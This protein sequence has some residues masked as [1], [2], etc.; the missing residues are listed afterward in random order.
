M[1]LDNVIGV[2]DTVMSGGDVDESF[3]DDSHIVGYVATYFVEQERKSGLFELIRW[4]DMMRDFLDLPFETRNALDRLNQIH[5]INDILDDESSDN[6]PNPQIIRRITEEHSDSAGEFYERLYL[7]KGITEIVEQ[8]IEHEPNSRRGYV[9]IT[10]WFQ[11]YDIKNGTNLDN[12]KREGIRKSGQGE[13]FYD[14]FRRKKRKNE[15][16][17]DLPFEEWLESQIS[18]DLSER[19]KQTPY[20]QQENV[21]I[22]DVVEAYIK[23]QPTSRKGDVPITNWFVRYGIN[24]ETNLNN[25]ESIRKLKQG[26]KFYQ[27]FLEKRKNEIPEDLPFEEW[28]ESQIS[29]ELS[30]RLKQTPYYQNNVSIEDVVE[31]Y[32]KHK[33]TSRKGDVSIKHWFQVYDVKTG[34]SLDNSKRDGTKKAGQ[35]NKFYWEWYEK[36][37]KNETPEDLPFENWLESQISSELSER[38]KQTPYYQ[39]NVSIEDVVEA[40]IQYQPTSRIGYV[41]ITSW[42]N[43][44]DI[45]TG[46]NLD[47]RKKG[48]ARKSRQGSKFYGRWRKNEKDK[49][50]FEEW[51][52]SQVS[53]EV[54]ERYLKCVVKSTL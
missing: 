24:T 4:P 9:P 14:I 15:I 1:T 45:K 7:R 8:F 18:S 52:L 26:E 16:P 22:E 44:Y 38:L 39:N 20:Y 48:S 36:K 30:E 5:P 37:R 10:R 21:S 34:T 17:E 31:A 47:N 12:S 33:P 46:T 35:G 42:F 11:V 3:L 51:V 27:R 23:Y 25:N 49:I 19:L 50:G 53:S 40:Y 43:F 32:I 54:R 41:P 28:L 6:F 29:P 13:K 2:L